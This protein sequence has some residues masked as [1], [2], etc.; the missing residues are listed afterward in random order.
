[1]IYLDEKMSTVKSTKS[2]LFQI[3]EIGVVLS[4]LSVFF[5]LILNFVYF[6]FPT[7]HISLKGVFE[8][9]K[10]FIV[11]QSEQG[12][13]R[14]L[15][16]TSSEPEKTSEESPGAVKAAVL[17]GLKNSVNS[18]SANAIAWQSAIHGMQLF[19]RD[20][21]QTHSN[22]T[23]EIKFH[24]NDFLHV[25]ENSLVIIHDTGA[26]TK[27]HDKKR[28]VLALID[29]E[30]WG[31]LNSSA[32]GREITEYQINLRGGGT[33]HIKPNP[34]QRNAETE[35]RMKVDS[36]KEET[37]VIVYKGLAEVKKA[38]KTVNV[39]PNQATVIA[40]AKEAVPTRP[41]RIPDP[42]K[43]AS[44]KREQKF[45]YSDIP[46]DITFNWQET[47][48]VT[49]YRITIASDADF[50]DIVVDAITPTNS[51]HNLDLKKGT[52]YWY[53]QGQ[54]DQV[55]SRRSEVGKFTVIHDNIPPKLIVNF[56]QKIV[57][58]SR[59][60]FSGVT[61]PGAAVYLDG[62]ELPVDTKGNFSYSM[63]LRPGINIIV[64]EAMDQIGNTSFQ[65]EQVF[66]KSANEK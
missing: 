38:G 45:V 24:D 29:G 33:A 4:I 31:R 10:A 53:V 32:T 59:Y 40:R 64:L 47:N 5:I 36:K 42:V 49:S 27:V 56:P 54:Q 21:I 12:K 18:K 26:T 63:D 52:Y 57:H 7:T 9:Q 11:N 13:R 20:A 61:D 66:F 58:K 65:S 44:P 60:S 48:G 16:A 43:L 2:I 6:I 35:F 19:N 14:L 62:I 51:F 15:S 50:N 46:P 25:G 34:K 17:S 1:M 30:L 8:T 39:A 3:G 28:S 55:S 22:S 37:T 23:A 41:I